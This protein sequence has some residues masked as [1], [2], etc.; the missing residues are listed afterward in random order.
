MD[1]IIN[2]VEMV[3]AVLTPHFM[4]TVDASDWLSPRMSWMSFKISL[5]AITK[6][7]LEA[8][9]TIFRF[10]FLRMAPEKIK[11]DDVIQAIKRFPAKLIFFEYR[12]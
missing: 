9:T 5:A 7:A 8:K 12:A 2:N 4:G 10:T 1:G 6:K 3:R 11:T